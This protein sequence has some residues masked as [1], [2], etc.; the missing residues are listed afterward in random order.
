MA[1]AIRSLAETT[2]SRGGLKLD[3]HIADY[4]GSISPDIEQAVYR[5]TQEALTN[6]AD[7][8]NAR[9]LT[10]QLRRFDSRLVLTV[11]D[12]GKRFDP[13]I[14]PSAKRFGIQGMQ[15]RAEMLGG[16][17]HVESQPSAGTVVMLS[18]E[19]GT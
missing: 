19:V 14:H 4:L 2:A 9:H 8:A 15:E 7:H 12:D 6:V 13:L 5:I 18:V 10:V 17:L 3:L 16:L 1:L 11:S